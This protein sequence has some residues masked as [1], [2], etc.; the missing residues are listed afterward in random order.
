MAR[1]YAEADTD[2]SSPALIEDPSTSLWRAYVNTRLAHFPEARTQ[3]A[4]GAEAFG[5]LPPLWRARFAR[6]EAEAAIAQG[7][8]VAA[9]VSIRQSLREKVS[10]EEQLLGRLVQARVIEL[11]G[12]KDR[13]L[14]SIR[15]TIDRNLAP[16]GLTQAQWLPLVDITTSRSPAFGRVCTPLPRSFKEHY[17]SCGSDVEG[18]DLIGH[19]DFEALITVRHQLFIDAIALIAQQ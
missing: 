2:F 4:K 11:Q 6:A 9:D 15:Q 5:L 13:A 1:R 16:H 14:Q 8:L 19:G 10:S 17:R 12:E 18:L 7:D 3:F